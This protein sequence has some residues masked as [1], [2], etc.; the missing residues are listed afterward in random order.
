MK[1][2]HQKFGESSL[3]GNEKDG[4][5]KVPWLLYIKLSMEAI[6]FPSVEGKAAHLLYLLLRTT[7]FRMETKEL[8]RFLF[9]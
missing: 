2:L 4:R 5:F 6:L 3:F 1:G 8:R 9:I 7:H